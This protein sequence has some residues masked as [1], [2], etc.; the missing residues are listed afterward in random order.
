M[1][2]MKNPERG[3]EEYKRLVQQEEMILEATELLYSLMEKTK[4][5]KADLARKLDRSKG[6]VTQVLD[7]SRNMTLRTL[8][9][10]GFALGYRVRIE[11]EPAGHRFILSR[12]PGEA[13]SSLSSE[14]R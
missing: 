10:F 13:A 9:D 2:P 6:F 14:R 11:A 1:T 4:I 12:A 3:S 5:T 8:S 7:G